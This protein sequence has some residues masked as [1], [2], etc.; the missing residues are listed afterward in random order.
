MDSTKSLPYGMDVR[1]NK[2]TIR[3]LRLDSDAAVVLRQDLLGLPVETVGSARLQG[4]R[5]PSAAPRP[6][7][8]VFLLR[9]SS[10]IHF[11]SPTNRGSAIL[12]LYLIVTVTITARRAD[13]LVLK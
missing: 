1:S 5:R 3:H 12:P 7:F 9:K 13:K 4:L 11:I 2:K 6:I 8:S 10:A